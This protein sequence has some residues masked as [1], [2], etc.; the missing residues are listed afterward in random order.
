MLKGRKHA[1]VMASWPLKLVGLLKADT[2]TFDYPIWTLKLDKMGTNKHIHQSVYT[3]RLTC[4]TYHSKL[5]ITC[6]VLFVGPISI[7]KSEKKLQIQKRKNPETY[8]ILICTQPPLFHSPSSLHFFTLLYSPFSFF[9]LYF[10][11]Y[12]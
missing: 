1:S 9:S 8:P 10:L 6:H 7:T 2:W 3:N 12:F 4:T 11:S 5:F